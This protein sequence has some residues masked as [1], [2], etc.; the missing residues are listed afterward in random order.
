MDFTEVVALLESTGY[1]EDK[2][3]FTGDTKFFYKKVENI[4][5]CSSNSKCPSLMVELITITVPTTLK[6][7]YL[8][9]ILVCGAIGPLWYELKAYSVEPEE[10]I[11]HKDLI[12]TNLLKA[13]EI[14]Q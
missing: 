11:E 4:R 9:D 12:E 3:A 7:V 10:F 8:I 14:L 1:R 2:S 6:K 13:W 5:E